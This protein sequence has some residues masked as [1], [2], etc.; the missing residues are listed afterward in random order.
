MFFASLR[1]YMFIWKRMRTIYS[2]ITTV[3]RERKRIRV[4]TI[5]SASLYYR[6]YYLEARVIIAGFLKES[7]HVCHGKLLM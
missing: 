7:A 4:A 2:D 1:I 6:Q 3:N 5:F